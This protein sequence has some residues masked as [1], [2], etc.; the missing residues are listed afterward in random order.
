V[1]PEAAGP[2]DAPPVSPR[3]ASDLKARLVGA[4]LLVPLAIGT[5]IWGGWPFLVFWT[6]AACVGFAEWNRLVPHRRATRTLIAGLAAIG[7]AAV[8][9]GL[10]QWFFVLAA[11]AAGFVAITLLTPRGA[12]R[13]MGFGVPYAAAI[14]IAPVALRADPIHGLA[15]VLVLFAAVWGTDAAA[16][17]AGRAFGG[18]KL[19]PRVSPNKTWSGAIGGVS[20]AVVAGLTLAWASGVA[21]SLGLAL[22]LVALS[23]A[24]QIG[25][26]FESGAKRRFGAKDAGALI[27]GHGGVLDR[28]DGFLVA[29]SLAVLIGVLRD[30]ASSPATGLLLW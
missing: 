4:A 13:W 15:G 8:A 28:V 3:K 30:G 9:V 11:L 29:A 5:A 22:V 1:T 23:V 20:F 25:D 26:L 17:F 12:R 14:V 7:G 27:P 18:P 21:P 2:A 10:G 19:W 6:L 16:Y 24:V